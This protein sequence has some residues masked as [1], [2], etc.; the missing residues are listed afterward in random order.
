MP[1]TDGV[2]ATGRIKAAWPQATVVAW[3][4]A[5]DARAAE[6]FFAAGASHYIVKDDVERLQAVLAGA[7]RSRRRRAA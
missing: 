1:G 3:T 4:S 5:D 7:R 6:R 2:E